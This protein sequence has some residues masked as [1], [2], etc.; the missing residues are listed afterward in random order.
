MMI[1]QNPGLLTESM[2]IVVAK[3]PKILEFDIKKTYFRRELKKLRGDRQQYSHP[4]SKYIYI[5]AFLMGY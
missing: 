5:N 4:L 1:R 2:S 3:M